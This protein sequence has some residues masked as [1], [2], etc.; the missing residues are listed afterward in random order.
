ML[1]LVATPIGNL[2]DISKRALETLGACDLILCEDTRRSAILLNHYGIQK[3]L[4]S[5]HK[6]NEKKELE[7]IIEQLQEG[8]N[9]ALISDAGTPCIADPGHVLVT[10]CIEH[11]VP[12]TSVGG[13][14]SPIE[15]LLLSGLSIERFQFLGFLPKNPREVLK[16]NRGYPGTT[17]VLESPERIVKTLKILQEFDAGRRVAVAREM[18]KAF[19]ECIRGTVG[20]VIERLEGKVAVKG[21][22]VL[23]I[24]EGKARDEDLSVEE[25]VEELQTMFGLSLKEAI[26]KAAKLAK[27]PKK[28]AYKKVHEP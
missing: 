19:E 28:I 2:S 24:G 3:K 6:F 10:T 27:I 4:L 17:I 16:K 7:K 14:C 15:A 5:Y 9:I 26:Q 1:Y 11:N 21:E 18:T 25:L 22:I 12:F 23:A 13:I 20:D 8:K